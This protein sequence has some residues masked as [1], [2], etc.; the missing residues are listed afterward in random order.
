MIRRFEMEPR[1][2]KPIDFD[3]WLHEV[4]LVADCEGAWA[5]VGTFWWSPPECCRFLVSVPGLW[6]GLLARAR[7]ADTLR[8]TAAI[9]R[10]R[11]AS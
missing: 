11:S 8:F 2:V 3:Q 9:V 7:Y 4:G 6:E 5:L 10:G 1:P